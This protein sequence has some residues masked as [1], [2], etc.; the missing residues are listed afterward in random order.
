MRSYHAFLGGAAIGLGG[1]AA[2]MLVHGYWQPVAAAVAVLGG[3][4][5]GLSFLVLGVAADRPRPD[6]QEWAQG[7]RRAPSPR[8][9]RQAARSA[10]TS[11]S[12]TTATVA[13]VKKAA[14]AS[15]NA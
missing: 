3:M 11:R 12:A 7:R 5:F 9:R 10:S 8:R 2:T 15:P 14:A 6:R 4:L 13:D 1:L